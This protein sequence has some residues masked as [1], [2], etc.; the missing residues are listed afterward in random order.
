MS[1]VVVSFRLD[2]KLKKEMEEICGK[3]GITLSAAYHIFTRKV[4]MEERIP[5]ELSAYPSERRRSDFVNRFSGDREEITGMEKDAGVNE[6]LAELE[7][8]LKAV[9]EID[10]DE[11]LME[12]LTEKYEL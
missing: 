3:M 1:Q 10:Y 4:V 2:E 9:P 11:E 8:V 6:N 7:K 5:F 12:A